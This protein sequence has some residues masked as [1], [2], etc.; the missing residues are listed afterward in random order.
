MLFMF[1]TFPVSKPLKSRLVRLLQPEN[2]E[3]ISVTSLVFRYSRPSTDNRLGLFANQLAVEVGLQSAKEESNMTPS[4][5]ELF[6]VHEPN[7]TE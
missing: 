6:I 7:P 2:M 5:F 1:V 3:L 4:R